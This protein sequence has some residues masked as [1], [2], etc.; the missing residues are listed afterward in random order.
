MGVD[1]LLANISSLNPPSL[2]FHRKH[3]FRECG[4]FEKILT[5]FG[6]DLDIVWMQKRL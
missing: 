2:E 6:Q 4:R 1:N 5:K 3:G